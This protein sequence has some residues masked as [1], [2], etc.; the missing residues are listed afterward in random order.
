MVEISASILDAKEEEAAKT[1][2]NLRG[3]KN[4]LFPYRCYGWEIC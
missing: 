4:R 3:C 2:Y 1:F